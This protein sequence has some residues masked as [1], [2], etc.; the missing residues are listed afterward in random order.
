MQACP[1]RIQLL[2]NLFFYKLCYVFILRVPVFSAGWL[3]TINL[4]FYFFI[5]NLNL[6]LLFIFVVVYRAK[7]SLESVEA[8]VA[9][10]CDDFS[11]VSLAYWVDSVSYP[12][13]LGLDLVSLVFREISVVLLLNDWIYGVVYWAGKM[14]FYFGSHFMEVLVMIGFVLEKHIEFWSFCCHR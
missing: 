9:A 3:H 7:T 14:V 8:S 12:F 2:I 6:P 10:I 13:V 11:S 1:W 4:L 5:L